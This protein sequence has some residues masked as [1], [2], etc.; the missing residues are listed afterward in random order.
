MCFLSFSCEIYSEATQYA[1]CLASYSCVISTYS[2][3]VKTS[4][5]K[6]ETSKLAISHSHRDAPELRYT[7]FHHQPKTYQMNLLNR[8]LHLA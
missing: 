2:M 6:K 5:V 1:Q 3:H 4:G 7:P 8:V